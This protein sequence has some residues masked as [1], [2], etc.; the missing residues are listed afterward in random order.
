MLSIFSFLG[1]VARIFVNFS[2][3]DTKVKIAGVN[4][5][6]KS[7]SSMNFSKCALLSE[8]QMTLNP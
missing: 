7:S 2:I 8:T 4:F 6:L 5:E 3:G 1:S